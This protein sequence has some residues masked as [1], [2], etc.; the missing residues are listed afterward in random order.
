MIIDQLA[1]IPALESS[2]IP[3][4]QLS[5]VLNNEETS[6]TTVNNL[7][8]PPSVPIVTANVG[9]VNQTALASPLNPEILRF[10]KMLAV[11]VPLMAVELKMR[12]EGYDPAL[13]S[14]NVPTA[15]PQQVDQSSSEEPLEES[16]SD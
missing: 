16:D 1:S 6:S 8:N 13:L 12:A 15:K 5:S 7:P 14:N 10:T 11:G 2:I 9:D 4:I 3:T